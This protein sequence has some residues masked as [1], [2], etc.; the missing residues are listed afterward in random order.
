MQSY[1][2]RLLNLITH[3]PVTYPLLNLGARFA[4]LS[5][6]KNPH[7]GC[8]NIKMFIVLFI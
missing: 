2:E 6:E 4:N 3:S 8:L 7:G 1:R 5:L